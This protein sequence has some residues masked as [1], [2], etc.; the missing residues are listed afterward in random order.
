MSDMITLART[1]EIGGAFFDW[2]VNRS[3]GLRRDEVAYAYLADDGTVLDAERFW[4]LADETEWDQVDARE[5]FSGWP[6]RDDLQIVLN[7]GSYIERGAYDAEYDW[8]T[9]EL[10][11]PPKATGERAP[12]DVSLL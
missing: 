7:D 1:L 12:D 6:V 11:V 5:F 8:S 10:R 9:W 4:R 3:R 2:R